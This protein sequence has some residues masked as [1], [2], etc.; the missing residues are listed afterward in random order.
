MFDVQTLVDI[1]IEGSNSTSA[2]P[3][4]EGEYIATIKEF[5]P[6][7]WSSKDGTMSGVSLDVSWEVEDANVT[8]VT[9]RDKNTVKQSIGLDFTDS[10]SLDMGRGKNVGLGRLREA[11]G[12]NEP[13]KPFSFN[14]LPGQI[15][16]ISVKHRS[17]NDGT[18]TVYAE[19]K[20]VTK[21]S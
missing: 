17:A 20:A 4:P 8:A 3:V 6:R 10:N 13:G 19:V 14:N 2:V 12:Q 11:I 16:K 7:P 9:G 15:A 18:D 1:Q 21:A 5:K